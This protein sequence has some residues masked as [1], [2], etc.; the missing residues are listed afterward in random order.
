MQLIKRRLIEYSLWDPNRFHTFQMRDRFQLGP[1]KYFL[2]ILSCSWMASVASPKI[3]TIDSICKTSRTH[4]EPYFFVPS[5]CLVPKQP[6]G[7]S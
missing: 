2:S 5:F 4:I 6:V 3:D 1:F 7:S